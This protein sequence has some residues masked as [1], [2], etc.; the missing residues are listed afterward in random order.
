MGKVIFGTTKEGL[1]KNI[2]GLV[3]HI[4]LWQ[5]YGCMCQRTRS[6]VSVILIDDLMVEGRVAET[7]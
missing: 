3:E 5:D 1:E 2:T 4:Y 6:K 7:K